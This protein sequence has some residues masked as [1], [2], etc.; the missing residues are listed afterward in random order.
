MINGKG[1]TPEVSP[2]PQFNYAP[3][4]SPASQFNYAP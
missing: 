4:V 3:E 2:T 1:T